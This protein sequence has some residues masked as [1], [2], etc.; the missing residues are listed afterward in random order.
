MDKKALLQMIICS[1]LW[2]IA[3]IFIKLIDLNPMV[4]A[5]FRS[6]FAA[7]TISLFLKLS[8]RKIYINKRIALSALVMCLSFIGFITANKLTTSANA[9]VLQYT[10]PVFIVAISIIFLK[11]KFSKVDIATI[12]IT[13]FGIILFFLDSMDFGGFLGN[14]ISVVSGLFLAILFVM[15]G[16][17]NETDRMNTILFGHVFTAVIGLPFIFTYLG[18]LSFTNV[19]MIAI[20]GVFQIGIPYILFAVAVGKCSPLTCSLVGVIEPILNP[21][22]VA[23]FYGEMPGTVSLIGCFVVLVTVTVWCVYK[24]RL[25]EV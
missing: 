22:W 4:I 25:S 24:N 19:G 20:L 15:M 8:K 13:L 2:S 11:K 18:A 9:I 17:F 3:G 14:V 21:L 16:E 12:M 5:G 1:V 6:T 7:I 23:L 10:Q